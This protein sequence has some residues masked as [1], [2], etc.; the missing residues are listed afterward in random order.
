MYWQDVI[1]TFEQTHHSF[2]IH[3]IPFFVHA[4]AA[5]TIVAD[6]LVIL[7][8]WASATMFVIDQSLI[9]G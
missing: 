5:N 6:V 7:I 4:Y 3:K 2:C 9:G 1:F 8:A